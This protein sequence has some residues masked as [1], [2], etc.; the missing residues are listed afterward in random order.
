MHFTGPVILVISLGTLVA[1]E[2][3]AAERRLRKVWVVCRLEGM[4]EIL[5][6]GIPAEDVRDGGVA[7]MSLS[8]RTLKVGLT[9]QIEWKELS[10]LSMPIEI[11]TQL[12]IIITQGKLWQQLTLPE[13]LSRTKS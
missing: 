6:D 5:I 8:R 1:G 9:V 10:A 2:S 3:S 7:L 13:L 12:N 4:V 11:H